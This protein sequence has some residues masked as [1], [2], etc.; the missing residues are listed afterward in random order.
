MNEWM[1]DDVKIW[2]VIECV[3]ACTCLWM[4]IMWIEAKAAKLITDKSNL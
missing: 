2:M 4:W 1:H 3:N